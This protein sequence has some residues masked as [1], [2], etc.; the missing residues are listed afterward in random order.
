MEGSVLLPKLVIELVVVVSVPVQW[1]RP[2]PS[3]LLAILPVAL[4][5]GHVLASVPPAC[6]PNSGVETTPTTIGQ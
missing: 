1:V 6:F 4:V 3:L 2:V 5:F